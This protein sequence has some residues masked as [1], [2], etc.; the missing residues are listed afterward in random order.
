MSPETGLSIQ[1]LFGR[2][3][4]D[5]RESNLQKSIAILAGLACTAMPLSVSAESE[6][7]E[8]IVITAARSPLAIGSVGSAVTV[9]TRDD[10]ERRQARY[11]TDLLRAVP[12]FAVSH[13]GGAGA[14]AQVRVRGAEANHVLVLIDGVRAND[15]A[16]GDEFRWEFLTA[17]NVERIEVVRGPQ[18][19]LW[20]SDAIAAVVHVITRRGDEKPAAGGYIEGGSEDTIN[21][22][23]HAGFG[24]AN[25]SL[26]ASAERLETD[27][28]N[29]SRS[30]DERDGSDI[31]TATLATRIAAGE[32]L[33]FDAG[34]R[35]VDAYT[36]FDATDFFVTGLPA[37]SDVATE[38]S[39]NL[40]H[41]GATIGDD[42]T[43]LL[44]RV[45]LRYLDTDNDNLVDGIAGAGTASERST[46]SYQADLRLG[47]DLL[48]LA[49]E[50]ESTDF[51]QYGAT[52]FGDPNQSQS[53]QAN[54][55][56]GDYQGHPS[57]RLTWLLSARFDRNSD[58]QDAVTGRLSLSFDATPATRLRANIGTGRKNPT[59]IERF[60]F[61][62]GQFVGNAALKPEETTSFDVGIE[63]RFGERFEAQATLFRQDL[64]NEINGF[65]FD[66]DTFLT[67]AENMDGNSR[68]SGVEL[69]ASWAVSERLGLNATYTYTDSESDE[70]TPELRRPRHAGSLHIDYGFL[71]QRGRLVLAADYGGTR[72]DVFFPPFPEPSAIVTLDRYWLL[73]LSAQYA[74]TPS[75]KAIARV[76]NLLE[77]EYEQ[78]YGYRTQGRA[79]YAGL[80]MD[81]GG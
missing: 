35:V 70:G 13:A 5:A 34:L 2:V 80:Q 54:S 45:N 43:R 68:R 74:M 40:L 51:R 57:G 29:I 3:G 79:L 20:G 53:M 60:G 24:G 50:H 25:W 23:L 6:T 75:V 76:S 64:E 47:G 32:R 17:A 16:T 12:G 49:L 15:P 56:I 46:I 1:P 65:V 22:A 37:D 21:G 63:H 77:A 14:Q 48:S 10:I 42:T 11:V 59:F 19:S 73:D 8:Q 62:P 27:G 41:A 44:Q 9:I 31:M 33:A 78:V 81:F 52:A 58:F 55:V 67:T 30:G 7:L 71:D 28:F 66:P 39:Q 36:Q 18:S 61:F 4:E 38:T 72:Q 69:A 26:S